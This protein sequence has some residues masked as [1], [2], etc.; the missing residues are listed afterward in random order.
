MN[1][2]TLFHDLTAR[3]LIAQSTS[4][5]ELT[6]LFSEPQTLYCG[7]DPTAGSLHIGHLVPLLMLKRFQDA[8]HQAIALIGGAT[9]MIGDPSFKATERTLNSTQTV[10]QWVDDLRQQITRTMTPHLTQPL[11]CVNNADWTGQVNVI[12]FFRDIGK[13]F[14]VNAMINRESVKQ[15]LARP[16]QGISFT[17]FS[18]SLL[19][20]FD[21]AHL[22]REHQCRLQIGGNDQWGNIVSGIDLTRRLNN[23]T[24]HGLTLP[25]I[26]KSDGTKFGKTEGGAVWLDASKT[27]P[28]A[29][30]QFWLN[31]DDA[32]VYRFLRYYTFLSVDEIARIEAEDAAR[33][34][35]PQAQQILAE[36][37]TAFVHGEAG[38]A[39][40]QRISDA[41]FSGAVAQLSRDELAQL[42]LDGLPCTTVSTADDV[43]ELLI[44]SQLASSKRQ[45]REWLANGAIHVNGEKMA[46]ADLSQGFA[47]F[48]RY[49]LLQRG[50]KQFALIKLS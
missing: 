22:N 20:S 31:T 5:D 43:V 19:Q 47:L 44:A 14:S 49:Y 28:Y 15:R 35:K 6:A 33:S 26:T 18:Y 45:A 1:S 21:F 37:I 48:D 27:S 46:D 13:H 7:F 3:G 29:F 24:V 30:Y 17:E 25:L 8:G 23:E 41:L 50:K 16:D 36:S 11:R 4:L 39:S 9:G 42:E 34:G 10:Q 40:A 38:L 32:D 12:D 2:Q